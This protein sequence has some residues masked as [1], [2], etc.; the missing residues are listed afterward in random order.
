MEIQISRLISMSLLLMGTDL[1]GAG[2]AK[3]ASGARESKATKVE[4]SIVMIVDTV[5]GLVG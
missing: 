4:A 3:V 2:T 5:R 1:D